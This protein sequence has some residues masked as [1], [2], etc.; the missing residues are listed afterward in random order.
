MPCSW[1]GKDVVVVDTRWAFANPQ[2][3]ESDRGNIAQQWGGVTESFWAALRVCDAT[4]SLLGDV[5]TT[6]CYT[7]VILTTPTFNGC[8]SFTSHLL[9]VAS[10]VEIA[11]TCITS[12][13]RGVVL[14]DTSADCCKSMNEA[15]ESWRKKDRDRG[16]CGLWTYHNPAKLLFEACII[17]CT[18]MSSENES[19]PQLRP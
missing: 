12:F 1:F 6:V 17:V 19:C 14:H 3:T 16:V 7:P 4:R 9:Y 13:V 18:H 15:V 11:L 8:M 5:N 10:P 2:E